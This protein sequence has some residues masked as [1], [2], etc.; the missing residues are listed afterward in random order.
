MSTA[1]PSLGPSPAW[2]RNSIASA[3]PAGRLEALFD[4]AYS[5]KVFC[6]ALI[7]F[8]AALPVV[9]Y[10]FF[11]RDSNFLLLAAITIGSV[12]SM[13]IGSRV[14]LFDGRFKSSAIRL[15]IDERYF[16]IFTWGVFFLFV[17]VTFST[18]ASIPIVSAIKG[19]SA[20]ALS[21]Q[22]GQFLKGREG[23]GIALLYISTFLVNTILPYGIVRM[24]ARGSRWR[25]AAA[26]VFFVFCISFLQKALFLNLVLPMLA[27]FAMRRRLHGGV[28]TAVLGGSMLLL[29]FATYLSLRGDPFPEAEERVPAAEY[30]SA[31]YAPTSSLDYFAWRVIAVPVFTA[32]DTLQVHA[33]EFE[34]A[35]LLGSTS[36]LLSA[37]FGLERINLERF[38]FA[39]QF[40]AWNDIANANA[41]FVLDGYVNF[42]WIG[43][44][45]F[46][47]L[48]GQIFRW[49]RLSADV[50]FRC[51]WT[52]FAFVLFSAPLIGMLFSNG[53]AYMLIHALLVRIQPASG[54][55]Q[56][57][58]KD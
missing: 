57:L 28:A 31:S 20:D 40:G 13:W 42:G 51:L 32:T 21:Q 5:L 25:H 54:S 14:P 55:V 35:N 45:I 53:F 26:V 1:S 10:I 39:H 27:L 3:T 4:P 8:Y 22:R 17:F 48:V 16:L 34:G 33:S 19:A 18:A 6:G 56:S 9:A 38:V 44:L 12:A 30:F 36:T 29:V 46:G 23:A 7:V 11:I 58:Q 15:R 41:V 49:F 2:G 47:I 50:G 24:Y 52:L 37:I 43:V